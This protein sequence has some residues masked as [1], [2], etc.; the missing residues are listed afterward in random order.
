MTTSSK[1]QAQKKNEKK[2]KGPEQERGSA[3]RAR[4]DALDEAI[5]ESFPASD[6]P[7]GWAGRDEPLSR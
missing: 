5:A 1:R 4:W 7:V 2:D 6:P 3:A